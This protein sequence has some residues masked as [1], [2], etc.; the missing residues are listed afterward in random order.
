MC[1]SELYLFVEESSW[2]HFTLLFKKAS[3]LESRD[4]KREI[5]TQPTHNF[6][7]FV[8]KYFEDQIKNNCIKK[9]GNKTFEKE[10]QKSHK[11]F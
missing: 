4:L 1:C 6:I 7:N 2:Q 5:S 10:F 9:D 3:K 8:T 11:V